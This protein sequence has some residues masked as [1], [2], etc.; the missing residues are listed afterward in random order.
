MRATP[1]S[2]ILLLSF[3]A[4]DA[5]PQFKRGDKMTGASLAALSISSGRS[6]VSFPQIRGYTGTHTGYDLRLGPSFGWFLS[7]A[8]AIGGI[9]EINP[10]GNKDTYKDQ[11][12]SFQQDK[13]NRL[14]AGAGVFIRHYFTGK[15]ALIPFA[16]AAISS[17]ISTAS[18][19]GY[20]YYRS[21]PD[22]KETYEGK[23]SGGS[24]VNAGVQLGLTKML[25]PHTGLDIFLG[26][27]FDHTRN[28]FTT[29]TLT[30][31][32]IN[33]SI[34]LRAENKPTTK[35]TAHGV[36]AGLGFQV[37]LSGKNK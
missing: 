9:L 10:S 7:S 30:D 34:D 18:T 35:Y 24:Y 27:S 3:A 28:T 16:Q 1:F 37:F 32:G 14:K 22:Y 6:T 20:K 8:T 23:S 2:L 13:I 36:M 21:S 31:N 26:Y 12:T 11:G 4:T 17:G 29:T 19:E 5:L 25:N 33:G 15:S